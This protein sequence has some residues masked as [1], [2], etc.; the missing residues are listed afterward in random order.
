M[1]SLAHW[2][3]YR[4]GKSRRL[5]WTEGCAGPQTHAKRGREGKN[6]N[7]CRAQS[8]DFSAP[9]SL[10]NVEAPPSEYGKI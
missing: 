6:L 4:D 8:M 1:V 2:Q 7:L 10:A 3:I 9:R 5:D